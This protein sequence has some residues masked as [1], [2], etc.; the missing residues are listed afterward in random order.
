[1]EAGCLGRIRFQGYPWGHPAAWF[2]AALAAQENHPR[3]FNGINILRNH[4]KQ[5]NLILFILVPH[6]VQ[7]SFNLKKNINS[8]PIIRGE[9]LIIY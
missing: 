2:D 3:T 8:S 5:P 9:P 6:H 4:A 7:L 1:M